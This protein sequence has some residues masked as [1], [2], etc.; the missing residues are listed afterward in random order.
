MTT[1]TRTPGQRSKKIA[2]W[3]IVPISLLA[4]GL[5]VS[6][7]SRA[8]FS[9]TTDNPGN[10]WAA[11]TVALE[12]NDSGKALFDVR[13]LAPGQQGEKC[14]TVTSRGSLASAVKL[15][16]TDAKATKDLD[17]HLNLKVTEVASCDAPTGAVIFDGSMDRLGASATGYTTGIG[18]WKPAGTPGEARG[19]HVQYTFAADAPNSTQGG[20]ASLGLVWEAQN[21]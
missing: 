10:N 15:Y 4:S 13:D 8:A 14:I 17:K 21:Q 12:D 5:I 7:A 2:A 18:S 3:S 20:T 16:A 1:T 9:A 6:Q 11:G 19:Y